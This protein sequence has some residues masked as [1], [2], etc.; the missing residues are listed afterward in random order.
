[1]DAAASPPVHRIRIARVASQPGI[2]ADLAAATGQ[3]V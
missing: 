1:L 3:R 2:G